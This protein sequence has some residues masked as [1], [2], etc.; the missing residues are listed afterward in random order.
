MLAHYMRNRRDASLTL[1]DVTPRSVT[2]PSVR[3]RV[4]PSRGASVEAPLGLDPLVIGTGKDCDLVV[5][6]PRVS[7]R[8]AELRLTEE[9]VLLKDLGSKNGTFVGSLR[10]LEALVDPDAKVQIGGAKLRVI[11]GKESSTIPLSASPCFGDALGGS[12]PMRA[13]FAKLERAAPTPE[14]I[15]LLGESG[16]GKEILAKAIHDTSPRKGGPFV[17][18]DCSA[19]T[20][21]LLQDKLFGHEK[22]A[23]TGAREP[24]PGLLE[25]ANGGTLFIDEIGELP[26]DLQ[27]MLLR[28]LESRQFMRLG[29]AQLRRF[30]ARIIA[31]THG[32]LKARL[33]ERT[34]REDLYYRLAV[35]EVR[36]PP[37]RERRDDIPLMVEHFLRT[38]SPPRTLDDLPANALKLL[39][40]YTWEGNVRELRNIVARLLIFGEEA[41]ETITADPGASSAPA[42]A[43]TGDASSEGGALNHLLSLPYE[44][45][46]D[47]VIE[48][49]M[50]AYLTTRLR[51][52]GGNVAKAA[53][54]MG[55]T[56]QFFY[57]LRK[58]YGLD[59]ASDDD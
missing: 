18:F 12:L 6:D 30:D 27:P 24:R 56:R 22:D 32:D 14:T 37:L 45:A 7:R 8:H 43:S 48:R 15:L 57:M 52:C 51:K 54:S 25:T 10:L 16:T 1:T 33:I 20:S 21:T 23:F 49:F 36:V 31:A 44:E 4:T 50:R 53:Q 42:P 5:A 58:K 55:I 35:V 40:A 59:G 46:R 39:Q 47:A 11:A 26:L 3:V 28:A 13:L 41:L 34:F 9:G 29:S 38:S 17:I 19:V 2:I